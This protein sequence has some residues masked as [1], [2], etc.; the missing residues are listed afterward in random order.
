MKPARYP[1]SDF[2]ADS[3]LDGRTFSRRGGWWSAI[4]LIRDPRSEVPFIGLY[5][6]QKVGDEWRTRKS[7]SLRKIAQV[8]QVI[9]TLN[10]FKDA[11]QEPSQ[12]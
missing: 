1:V 8:D 6:W 7:F 9:E 5:R 2:Y 12:D 3:V 10:Q 11:L 4:L